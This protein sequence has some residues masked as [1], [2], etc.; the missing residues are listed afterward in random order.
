MQISW[1]NSGLRHGVQVFGL[2]LLLTA[3]ASAA[4]F[5]TAQHPLPAAEAFPLTIEQYGHKI[6]II[7]NTAADYYLYQDKLAFTTSNNHPLTDLVLPQAKVK[8]DP[9]FG[10]TNV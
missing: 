5:S 3:N 1:I 10:T 9:T 7:W 4:L 6:D 2:L 8:Q